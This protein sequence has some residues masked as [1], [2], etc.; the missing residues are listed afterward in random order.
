MYN[1]VDFELEMG[2]LVF[3]PRPNQGFH[4]G[5]AVITAMSLSYNNNESVQVLVCNESDSF[6]PV[7]IYFDRRMT[8]GDC[9]D[10]HSGWSLIEETI[11]SY[12]QNKPSTKKEI[13]LTYTSE[14]LA[15]DKNNY[16][17][18]EECLGILREFQGRYKNYIKN[19]RILYT[20][21]E[22]PWLSELL[23]Y[24]FMSAE[25][26]AE[27]KVDPNVIIPF[28][29]LSVLISAKSQKFF[30]ENEVEKLVLY[31]GRHTT[32]RSFWKTASGVNP[33]IKKYIHEI[34]WFPDTFS[35]YNDMSPEGLFENMPLGIY[36]NK[37]QSRKY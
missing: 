12:N 29:R 7:K 28:I 16:V 19:Q 34:G 33:R 10:C 22:Y 35:I 6:C 25:D 11:E 37:F 13:K 20:P 24:T 27:D 26:V 1:K 5:F 21:I 4:V 15:I 31:N 30:E 8:Y 9:P 23:T 18:D 36:P 32:A 17:S 2:T 14:I 3:I